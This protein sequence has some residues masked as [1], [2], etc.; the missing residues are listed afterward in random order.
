MNSIVNQFI[1]SNTSNPRVQVVNAPSTVTKLMNE[2]GNSSIAEIDRY[3][4]IHVNFRNDITQLDKDILA[5]IIQSMATN[6]SRKR[7]F[8]DNIWHVLGKIQALNHQQIMHSIGLSL[9]IEEE[10]L[11]CNVYNGTM[12]AIY[13]DIVEELEHNDCEIN[14][15]DRDDGI[16]IVWREDDIGIRVKIQEV[17]QNA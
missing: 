6:T 4:N 1:T 13:D 17:R 11:V 7:V 15:G 2:Q 3:G 10:L 8:I 5:E 9:D 14:I 16:M 12:P